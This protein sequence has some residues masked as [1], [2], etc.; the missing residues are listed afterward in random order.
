MHLEGIRNVVG[1]QFS[2][3]G[4]R[5]GETNSHDCGLFRGRSC[6]LTTRPPPSFFPFFCWMFLVI[7]FANSPH[8]LWSPSPAFSIHLSRRTSVPRVRRLVSLFPNLLP[9]SQP[10]PFSFVR[11]RLPSVL[12][13]FATAHVVPWIRLDSR[14]LRAVPPPPWLAFHRDPPGCWQGTAAR[15]CPVFPFSVRFAA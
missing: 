13:P 6:L 1:E 10:R 7:S 9:R 4:L 14:L 11:P 5:P 8:S 12:T 2:W 15:G 3:S